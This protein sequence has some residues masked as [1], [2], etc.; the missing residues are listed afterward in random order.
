[1]GPGTG[2]LGKEVP[3]REPTGVL[4]TLEGVS[5][6]GRAD[7]EAGGDGIRRERSV[8]AGMPSFLERAGRLESPFTWS[9]ERPAQEAERPHDGEAEHGFV[10]PAAFGD[11]LDDDLAVPQ[12]LAVI[13]DTVRRGNGA[14]DAGDDAAAWIAAWKVREMTGILGIDPGST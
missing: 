5:G 11:A 7:A 3:A 14:L 12:A 2:G 1:V 13:H 6:D 8:G 9:A 4:E 10:L